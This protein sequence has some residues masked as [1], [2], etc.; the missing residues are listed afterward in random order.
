MSILPPK[1]IKQEK[2]KVNY[3]YF[4]KTTV[5]LKIMFL[6]KIP[7]E[8]SLAWY[9]PFSYQP[10]WVDTHQTHRGGCFV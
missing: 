6:E 9:E 1:K 4:L 5:W 2:K 7:E 8:K 3:I 10:P